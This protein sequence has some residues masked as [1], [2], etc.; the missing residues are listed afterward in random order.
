MNPN[1][2][3]FSLVDVVYA[4]TLNGRKQIKNLSRVGHCMQNYIQNMQNKIVS[5]SIISV[6][7]IT[8]A[9]L[10]NTLSTKTRLKII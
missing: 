1:Q 10:K 3:K 2:K 7:V 8:A 9:S 6:R 4:M 5:V